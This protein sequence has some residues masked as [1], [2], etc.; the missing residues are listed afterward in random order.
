MRPEGDGEWHPIPSH[1]VSYVAAASLDRF[2]LEQGHESQ[3]FKLERIQ[4]VLG[5][6]P[7]EMTQLLDVSREGMRKWQAGGAMAPERT[8]RV[9]DLYNL[10]I[11]LA[12]HIRP[13]SLPAF[14]RRNIQALG[15]Q[16]PFEWLRSRRWKE[17]R[18]VYERI[19]SLETTR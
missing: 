1:A 4:S 11:W 8:T 3:Q 14:V 6:R 10:T 13:E 16:T 5:L 2:S 7:G 12:S 17:L 15:G 18:R 19:F 9:D